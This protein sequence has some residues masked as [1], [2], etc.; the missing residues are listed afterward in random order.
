M[1]GVFGGGSGGGAPTTAGY[2]LTAPSAALTAETLIGAIILPPD[3]IASR[4]AA[5]SVP[6]GALYF[7]TDDGTI[8]RSTGA[9][10]VDAFAPDALS[11]ET[12]LDFDPSPPAGTQIIRARNVPYM[13]QDMGTA[14]VANDVAETSLS[15]VAGSFPAGTLAVGDRFRLLLFGKFLNDTG[16]NAQAIFRLKYNSSTQL[17]IATTPLLPAS[18]TERSW[19]IDIDGLVINDGADKATV[20]M[21]LNLSDP[22]GT[23][24]DTHRRTAAPTPV[25]LTLASVVNLTVT[26]ELSAA[27]ASLTCASRA[28]FLEHLAAA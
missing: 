23:V 6:A 14:T 8:T 1:S 15:S 26:V 3:V 7:A 17:A 10:W 5:A 4:P 21:G 20:L 16:G 22:A 25:A 2:V 27:S 11:L 28:V 18:A 9:A 12:P 19:R 24:T 13:V